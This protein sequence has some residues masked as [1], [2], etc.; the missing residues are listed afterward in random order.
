MTG[1]FQVMVRFSIE[2]E[3]YFTSVERIVE[4]IK[5]CES[6]V[7]AVKAVTSVSKSW[8]QEGAIE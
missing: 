3:S 2:T 4:Y 7:S 8:P 6:E 1:I 5:T